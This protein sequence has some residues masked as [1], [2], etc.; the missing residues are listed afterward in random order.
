[1]DERIIMLVDDDISFLK[2]MKEGLEYSIK[3]LKLITHTNAEDALESLK[4]HPISLL[5]TDQ[6]LP[7]MSGL[8]FVNLVDKKYPNI[9]IILITAYGTPK[10][11][12]YA[13]DIGAI[14]FFDKP[15]DLKEMIREV[16]KGL[17]LSGEALTNIRKISLATVLELISM[18][19]KTAS[20]VVK[21][22]KTN[23]TG[24]I[25]FKEGN[26]IDAEADNLEGVEAV[27]EMLSFGDVDIV[28]REREHK[29]VKISDVPLE[30]ILL[31]GMKRLDETK[32]KKEKKKED[33]MALNENIFDEMSTIKGFIAAA[34][35]LGNGEVIISKTSEKMP[36]QKMGGLAIEL[37][38]VAKD[39]AN[40]M[41][42]GTADFVEI[43]TEKYKFI[44][45]CIVPGVAAIGLIISS[46]GN[47]GLTKH[48][49]SNI[50]GALKDDFEG[51]DISDFV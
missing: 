6:K 44:H 27:F 23:K 33:I 4:E 42:I 46:E 34:I 28:V 38:K 14:K 30:Y 25:W 39:F 24:R 8:E 36:I 47:V 35:Y 20:V 10:I 13:M 41:N 31:E 18:E 21:S 37:Y 50:K 17:K 11:K 15:V 32:P 51:K 16:K 45:T 9:P 49:M 2:N 5:I 48:T 19:K 12:E 29:R 1:M 22:E 43:H 3:N 40:R 26:L 7:G